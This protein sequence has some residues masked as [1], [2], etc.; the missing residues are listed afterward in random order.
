VIAVW[1]VFEPAAR[2]VEREM[3]DSKIIAR[4]ASEATALLQELPH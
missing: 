1:L 3:R 4:Y 2:I